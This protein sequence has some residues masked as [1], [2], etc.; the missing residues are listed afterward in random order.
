[1]SFKFCFYAIGSSKVFNIDLLII[2]LL[3]FSILSLL[4][5]SKQS[6]NLKNTKGN[7]LNVCC[8]LNIYFVIFSYFTCCLNLFKL[9]FL[10]VGLT[11]SRWGREGL[12][13]GSG[14][15]REE[16][17]ELRGGQRK[18]VDEGRG[19]L[20][21]FVDLISS[22]WFFRFFETFNKHFHEQR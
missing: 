15:E 6:T 4:D 18:G 19:V 7:D 2:Y 11:K 12:G 14:G 21:G 13:E 10:G 1:M 8:D 9:G 3:T 20:G 17:G 5:Q 22:Y 16:V